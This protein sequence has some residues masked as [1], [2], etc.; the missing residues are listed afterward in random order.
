MSYME[1]NASFYFYPVGVDSYKEFK[2]ILKKSPP[3]WIYR[4]KQIKYNHNSLGFREKELD[5]VDWN[6]S[7]VILGCSHVYGD[8][9]AEEDSAVRVLEKQINMPVINL[10]VTSGSVELAFYNSLILHEM[11]VKPKAIIQIW[12]DLSRYSNFLKSNAN[13]IHPYTHA[14]KTYVRRID[15]ETKSLF[16]IN[17]FNAIWKDKTFIYEASFF[18]N[19]AT[20]CNIDYIKYL[21]FA[22]DNSHAGII[23]HK[24]LADNIASKL[25][26]AGVV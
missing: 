17:A 21:D 22:R 16:Y 23:T 6:N 13:C 5:L 14:D 12:S 10:G 11:G 3:D 24:V 9:L 26:D 2:K 8:A 19:T 4:T 7:V 18:E 15:W 1:K 20:K 25:I